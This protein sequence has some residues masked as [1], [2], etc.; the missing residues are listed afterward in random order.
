MTNAFAIVIVWCLNV[1][2][3]HELNPETGLYDRTTEFKEWAETQ[4]VNSDVVYGH[5]ENVASIREPGPLGM[6][7][8]KPIDLGL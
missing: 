7:D 5:C 8:S 2:P 3:T 4:D 1:S 6:L